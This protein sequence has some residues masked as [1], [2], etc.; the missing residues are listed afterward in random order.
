[1]PLSQN[2][3]RAPMHERKITCS[4]YLRDDGLW[5]VEGH[6]IDTKGYDFENYERGTIGTGDHVHEMWL[7]LTVDDDYLIHNVEAVTDHAPFAICPTITSAFES[8]AGLKIAP[9]WNRKARQLVGGVKGCTHLV[10][11]LGPLG[12]TV[13]QTV[14]R[15]RN[16]HTKDQ[17][18]A[19]DAS[20]ESGQSRTRP[21]IIDTCHALKADGEAVKQ[22]WPE[23][24][25]GA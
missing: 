10:E 13:L 17:R 3:P 11:L 23:F 6:L 22:M 15:D 2:A 18:S 14:R 5:D 8:L 25:E 21:R 4:G 19:G 1:M 20:F 7:R 12:T 9:G 16:P 24:Y